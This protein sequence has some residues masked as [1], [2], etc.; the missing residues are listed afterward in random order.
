MS[1]S[2]MAIQ[3][4]NK[5]LFKRQATPLILFIR[6]SLQYLL[7]FHNCR[8][9]FI[10]VPVHAGILRNEIADKLN[11][12]TPVSASLFS[13]LWHS[14]LLTRHRNSHT[15][16]W[17]THFIDNINH[18][19]DYFRIQPSL[20]NKFWFVNFPNL[21]RE[22]IVSICR[23]RLDSHHYLPATLACFIPNVSPYFS[24]HPT[25]VSS[26]AQNYKPK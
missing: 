4:I 1:D 25:T 16:S 6:N 24:L 11:R 23:L 14:D 18:H 5:P 19:S 9:N 17:T 2:Q 12:S 20:P 3:N 7:H 15:Q 21:L 26:S 8:T 22:A 10:W 13:L